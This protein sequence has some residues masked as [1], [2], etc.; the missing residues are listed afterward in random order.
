MPYSSPNGKP[1]IDTI[2]DRLGRVNSVLD[3]GAGA[4]TYSKRYRERLGGEWTA[5]EIWEP[6]RA[7]FGLDALYDHVRIEDARDFV[8]GFV[9]DA[10]DVAFAGDVLEHM[11]PME[12]AEL[13][14]QLRRVAKVVVVSLPLGRYPQPAWEGNPYERHVKDDWTVADVVTLLGEAS[15]SNIDGEIGVFVYGRIPERPRAL[16]VGVYAIMKDEPHEFVRRFC[17]S[18]A[19]ADHVLIADTGSTNDC[20]AVARECGA[21][22]VPIVVRPWRFDVARDTALALLPGNLDVCISLDIDEV[23]VP[24]W[25]DEIERVWVKGQTTR[26]RYQ[27]DWGC[28]IA[29]AYEKIHARDGYH[30]HHPVHEYPRPDARMQEVYAHTDMLLVQHLPDATKSR[31]QYLD[32]LKLAVTED[33]SCPRNAFYYARELSF[34]QRW[35]EC[36]A[37]CHRYL[38]LPGATWANERCYAMR[39]LSKAHAGLGN[40]D[41]AMKWARLAVAE[42]P[43]TRE[44]WCELAQLCHDRALWPECYGAAR[45]AL[46]ITERQRVY[47]CDPRVWGAW[48]HDLA[49]LSAWQIGKREESLEHARRAVELDPGDARLQ[50][51]VDVIEDLMGLRAKEAA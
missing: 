21:Q 14:R 20:A 2:V 26:L 19:D 42:A 4:G 6:Y 30:W 17:A 51:N 7:R 15:V 23:L 39:V 5:L 44:P 22:V 49:S 8:P 29:F 47:T 36:I 45:S 33:S 24:G 34:Y 25:R 46:A 32:L 50:A 37:Q 31:G 35:D 10:F 16:R 28:G 41:E 40:P 12:A 11:D 48:P 3:I 13:M 38:G 43:D 9:D 18:A 1:F 27:F